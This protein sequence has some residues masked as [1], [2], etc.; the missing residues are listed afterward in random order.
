MDN[1]L[2]AKDLIRV[3]IFS[4]IYL[5]VVMGVAS[6]GYIPIFIP[7]LSVLV[8]I[9]SGIPFMLFLTKVKKFGM[10]W[11]MSIIFG[12]FM[13]ILG[14]GIMT[15]PLSVITG[16]ACEFILKSGHY[17]SSK[18]SVLVF[19]VFSIAIFGNFLQI[20]IAGNSYFE[21]LR[22]GF[23]NEYADTLKS[24]FPMWIFPVLFFACFVS[25]ILGGLLGKTVLKKHF[26]KAGIA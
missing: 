23:G 24:F 18:K 16:L 25:G 26:Q 13:L 10:V 22:S 20:L 12:I 21:A 11:I 2:Q 7:L 17:A 3:G 1:K 8:P 14:M 5:I 4:A 6:I 19:G 15:L 9:I